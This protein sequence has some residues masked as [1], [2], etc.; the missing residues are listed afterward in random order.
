MWLARL[1]TGGFLPFCDLRADATC[2]HRHPTEKDLETSVLQFILN[3]VIFF[4]F[5]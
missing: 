5:M 3:K 4:K 1:K 2:E